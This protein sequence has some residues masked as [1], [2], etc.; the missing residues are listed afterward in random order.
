MSV[1]VT[2][3][4]AIPAAALAILIRLTHRH[5]GEVRAGRTRGE[6][7]V[8]ADQC[9]IRF[10]GVLSEDLVLAAGD[11]RAVCVDDR[12]PTWPAL[13]WHRF[14]IVSHEP[15]RRH[16]GC[17]FR[18]N[19]RNALQLLAPTAAVPNVALLFDRPLRLGQA[20]GLGQWGEEAALVAAQ[21]DDIES[22]ADLPGARPVDPRRVHHGIFLKVD[23]AAA[24]RQAFTDWPAGRQELRPDDVQLV[25][26][27]TPMPVPARKVAG[28]VGFAWIVVA[29]A[30]TALA[31][32][33]RSWS[34]V[35]P[36]VLVPAAVG[37][38]GYETFRSFRG[39]GRGP[40]AGAAAV[41]AVGLMVV[42]AIVGV[43]EIRDLLTF[44][45]P[46]PSRPPP[47]YYIP[48]DP[49]PSPPTF[50]APSPGTSDP[51]RP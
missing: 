39:L 38:L 16:V 37:G 7:T 33:T 49:F 11:I 3:A 36:V 47:S 43:F 48:E 50:P 15:E 25:P 9:R 30:A 40:R 23:S 8:G 51:L 5:L 34:L 20:T 6:V 29:I 44:D 35:V 18:P 32:V 27:I 21:Y 31:A 24:A 41:V 1:L 46:P 42:T 13:Y 26:A 17:L 4:M 22:L 10:P 45:D 14:P 19:L 12:G 28:A 2:A